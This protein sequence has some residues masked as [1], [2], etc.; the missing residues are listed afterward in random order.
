MTAIFLSALSFFIPG[1]ACGIWAAIEWRI[2]KKLTVQGVVTQAKIID[3]GDAS[4]GS[5]GGKMYFVA[6][7][8]Q[9]EG[10][11]YKRE[12]GVSKATYDAST[13]GKRITIRYLP[14]HPSTARIEGERAM[15][16]AVA[17]SVA[18]VGLALALFIAALTVSLHS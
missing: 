16:A 18:L 17:V 9:H 11:S 8:Y 14:D 1:I 5:H 6:Y 7:R 4:P 13:V 2:Q 10:I 15:F 12:Q 3:R